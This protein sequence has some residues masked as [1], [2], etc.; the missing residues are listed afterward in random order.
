LKVTATSTL[1]VIKRDDLAIEKRQQKRAQAIAIL[2]TH[3]Y[4]LHFNLLYIYSSY[5]VH[6]VR[7]VEV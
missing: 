7:R 4:A 5:I 1:F 6:V 3:L 2:N